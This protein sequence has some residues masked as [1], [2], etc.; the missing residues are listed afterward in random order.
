MTYAQWERMNVNSQKLYLAGVIDTFV[1][2]TVVT[3]QASLARAL[4]Y[5]E[6]L[7][8]SKMALGQ[9]THNVI[10]FV[11]SAPDLQTEKV[12]LAV[13]QYMNKACGEAPKEVK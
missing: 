2:T 5:R 10:A 6:C 9:L 7:A 8:R 3:D 12:P 4:H 13:Q 1:D 11:S